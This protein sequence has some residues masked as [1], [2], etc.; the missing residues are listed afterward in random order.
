MPQQTQ[1]PIQREISWACS[2]VRYRLNMTT[3]IKIAIVVVGKANNI[4]NT[5]R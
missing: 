2:F 3:L 5:D 1:K 4:F